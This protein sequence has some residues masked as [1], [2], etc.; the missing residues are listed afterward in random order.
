MVLM[1]KKH[2]YFS[3]YDTYD[4]SKKP[5]YATYDFSKNLLMLLMDFQKTYLWYLWVAKNLHTLLTYLNCDA[6]LISLQAIL[7]L[8]QRSGMPLATRRW[9]RCGVPQ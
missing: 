3:T 7:V 9:L 8:D 6:R 1:L 5:T 2:T 4:F